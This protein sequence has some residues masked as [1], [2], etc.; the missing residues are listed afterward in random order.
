M[1]ARRFLLLCPK[2]QPSKSK[3][4]RD[5][6]HRHQM[7]TAHIIPLLSKVLGPVQMKKGQSRSV[8]NSITDTSEASCPLTLPS[9]FLTW[10]RPAATIVVLVLFCAS[11][12]L[13]LWLP[14]ARLF[15][16][17]G[18][19]LLILQDPAW[20]ETGLTFF[21]SLRQTPVS[22]WHSAN[23]EWFSPCLIILFVFPIRQ[24]TPE[25][26]DQDCVFIYLCVPYRHGIWEESK[27]CVLKE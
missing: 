7:R 19:L 5:E 14:L 2:W 21:E 8:G 13:S 26:R 10:N 3:E 16:P 22:P 12:S 9:H 20:R 24:R 1:T 15:A 17:S 23:L 4:Q 18:E 6:E 27:K 11:L 25:G